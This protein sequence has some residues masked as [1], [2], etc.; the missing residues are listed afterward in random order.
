MDII[1]MKSVNKDNMLL[2][3]TK[4]ILNQAIDYFQQMHKMNDF[5][6]G[7]PLDYNMRATEFQAGLEI[8]DHLIINN[9]FVDE[10]AFLLIFGS[11][12]D[13]R[14]EVSESYPLLAKSLFHYLEFIKQYKSN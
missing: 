12:E 1:E 7:H 10:D 14:Q 13:F 11:A 3:R 5:N 4:N 2:D 6:D 8:L 9:K